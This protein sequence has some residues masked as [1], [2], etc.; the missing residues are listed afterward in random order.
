ML[1]L[2]DNL[3]QHMLQENLILCICLF[4]S[5][6]LYGILDALWALLFACKYFIAL[7]NIMSANE[8]GVCT[9][10]IYNSLS[11]IVAGQLPLAGQG[12]MYIQ[13]IVYAVKKQGANLLG[14]EAQR[15]PRTSQLNLSYI[16][17]L[18]WKTVIVLYTI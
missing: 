6:I 11:C 7:G 3:C 18:L 13:Y 1:W 8:C 15:S 12:T 14:S 5:D 16:Y 4:L 2:N 9:L 10:F 17:S